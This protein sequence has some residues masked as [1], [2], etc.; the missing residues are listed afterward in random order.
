MLYYSLEIVDLSLLS[1][2][3]KYTTELIWLW[4]VYYLVLTYNQAKPLISIKTPRNF[5]IT[6]TEIGYSN[7][8]TIN[9]S[10]QVYNILFFNKSQY[11]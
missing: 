10:N 4:F 9:I 8:N 2:Q 7:K 3:K 5:H 6:T 1:L 11:S